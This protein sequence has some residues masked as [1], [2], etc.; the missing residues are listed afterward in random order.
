MSVEDKLHL[1]IGGLQQKMRS[2][3]TLGNPTMVEEAITLTLHADRAFS[4]RT[5]ENSGRE[6]RGEPME[7]GTTS[8]SERKYR[9]G[10]D[11]RKVSERKSDEKNRPVPKTNMNNRS[12]GKCH[13]YR[14]FGHY[15]AN[16]SEEE[17]LK[18]SSD[19]GRATFSRTNRSSGNR[20]YL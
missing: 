20:S 1:Y 9:G 3:V 16:C 13:N 10:S 6:Y 11:G 7:L 5:Q 17:Q 18:A 14:K 19:E 15:A 8:R 12:K 4:I 2:Q